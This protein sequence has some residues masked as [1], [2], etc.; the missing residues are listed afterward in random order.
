MASISHD[1]SE[2]LALGPDEGQDMRLVEMHAIADSVGPDAA[3][4]HIERHEQPAEVLSV[5]YAGRG[6][7]GDQVFL[8][9]WRI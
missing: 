6:D 4:R 2:R 5:E 7:Y 9:T 3:R 8:V 1:I